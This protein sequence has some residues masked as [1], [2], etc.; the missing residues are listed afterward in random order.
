MLT[1]FINFLICNM[2]EICN[3][4]ILLSLHKLKKLKLTRGKNNVGGVRGMEEGES[5]KKERGKKE[6]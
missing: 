6:R 5:E 2:N 4:D 3:Y 1:C